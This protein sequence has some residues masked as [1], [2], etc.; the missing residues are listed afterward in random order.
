MGGGFILG[1]AWGIVV[2]G[3]VL[4]AM[5]LSLPLPSRPAAPPSV[6]E[7]AMSD[8]G[9]ETQVPATA[10][11]PEPVTDTDGTTGAAQ[12][13]PLPAGSEFNRP[14]PPGA[15]ILPDTDAPVARSTPARVPEAADGGVEAGPDAT[16]ALDPSPP[17]RAR[18]GRRPVGPRRARGPAR[19][20][21]RCPCR[22]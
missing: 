3:I 19:R 15:A 4:A 17:P 1:T 18:G 5:S 11:A 13:V 20:G 16:P 8:T 21:L 10:S 22:R 9:A 14:P 12:G 2:A 7:T 6:V